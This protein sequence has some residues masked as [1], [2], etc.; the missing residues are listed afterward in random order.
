VLTFI[1]IAQK[2]R[3]HIWEIIEAWFQIVVNTHGKGYQGIPESEVIDGLPSI[4]CGVTKVIENEAYL[5]D[6]EPMGLIHQTAAEFGKSRYHLG[7]KVEQLLFEYELLRRKTWRF[8]HQNIQVNDVYE[9]EKR[10]NLALDKAIAASVGAYLKTYVAEL[11]DLARRDRLTGLYNYATFYEQLDE[12]VKRA[13]R[14][15]RNLSIMMID[16]DEF[17]DYNDQFGHKAGDVAL[18]EL[19]KIFTRSVRHIDFLARYGGDEF[20]VILPETNKKLARRVAERMRRAIKVET[21]QAS[22]VRGDI[23]VPLTISIGIAGY[24]K[25][26]E[27]ADDLVLAADDALY[28]AKEQGRDVIV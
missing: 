17:K 15:R 3:D 18:H 11:K 28:K 16:I 6:F 19:A 14:F 5:K 24:P 25:D 27:T 13:K 26:G 12:E 8:C 10:V 7:V 20:M 23:K 2:L 1:N 21:T 9:L 22:K 4:L